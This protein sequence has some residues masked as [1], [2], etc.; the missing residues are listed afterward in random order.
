M[1]DTLSN[2]TNP[3]FD[4]ILQIN[5]PDGRIQTQYQ[6]GNTLIQ[7]SQ[8]YNTTRLT[9]LRNSQHTQRNIVTK[10]IIQL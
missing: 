1:N 8:S 3:I 6:P 10:Y 2:K 5:P 7:L 4:L 9:S